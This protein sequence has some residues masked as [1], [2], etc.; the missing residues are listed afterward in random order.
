[1]I[2][3]YVEVCKNNLFSKLIAA[4]KSSLPAQRLLCSVSS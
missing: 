3:D 4:C 1:M 2:S